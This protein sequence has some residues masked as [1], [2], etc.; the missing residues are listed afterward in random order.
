MN[1]C[2]NPALIVF[3]REVFP[4]NSFFSAWR[5]ND[6][7]YEYFITGFWIAT[8]L[9]LDSV[10]DIFQLDVNGFCF[11][12]SKIVRNLSCMR[13]A[14]IIKRRNTVNLYDRCPSRHLHLS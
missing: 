4:A 7:E 12:R 3:D 10:R 8:I 1:T 11:K 9:I 5:M 6:H 2:L 13:L 14:C